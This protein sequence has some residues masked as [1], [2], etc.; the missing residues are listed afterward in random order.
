MVET[1]KRLFFGANPNTSETPSEKL[2]A[3]MR[4]A[5]DPYA[6]D[7]QNLKDLVFPKVD[8]RV[9]NSKFSH[10]ASKITSQVINSC[11]KKT[12]SFVKPSD[13]PTLSDIRFILYHQY[14]PCRPHNSVPNRLKTKPMKRETLTLSGLCCKY[15]AKVYQQ[16]GLGIDG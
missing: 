10:I 16:S 13:F 11:R 8:E 3:I 1:A 9:R 4:V 7:H 6:P 12:T 5:K 2:Q 14:I 15:C